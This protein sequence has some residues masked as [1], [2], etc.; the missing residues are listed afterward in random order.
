MT[1][2]AEPSGAAAAAAALA[3]TLP[4]GC[5]SAVVVA[6]GVAGLHDDPVPWRALLI[7]LVWSVPGAMIAAA[8][9]RAVLGWL[10]LAVAAMFTTTGLLEVWLASEPVGPAAAVAWGLWFVDRAGALIVPATTLALVLLP[11]SRLPGPGWRLPVAGA[12]ALQVAL[13]A[14]W[15]LAETPAAD[16]ES[17]RPPALLAL[18]N[19]AG[20]L[21][22]AWAGAADGV[23]WLL[24]LPLL[25]PLAAMA[26][27]IR[28]G[29]ALERQRLAAILLSLVVLVAVILSGRAVLGEWSDL[30][31][32]LAVLLLACVLVSAVLRR[33]LEGVSVVVHHAFVLALLGG[34][35]AATYVVSVGLLAAVGP[36]LSRFGAGVVA[37]LAAL[38]AQ[39][40]HS[41]LQG[42]VDRLLRGDRR[43]PYRAVS[44]LVDS[45]HRAPSLTDVLERVATS[46][47]TSVRLPAVEVTAFGATGRHPPDRAGAAAT[48]TSRGVRV[49]LL[50]G[51]REVGSLWVLPQLGRR[52]RADEV[53]L[54]REL[55][56]HAGV[57]VDAVHLAAQVAEHHRAVVTAREEE[58]RRLGRELHDE[59]GPT[60]AGLAMQL[61]A[62]RPLVRTDPDGVVTRLAQLEVAAAGAL[63]GLRRVAHELRPPVLDQVGLDRA[64]RQ[65]AD[66]LGLSVVEQV[67]EHG[68]LPAAV[69][70]AAYRIVAE[71]LT[72][73][74]RHSGTR[75][76]RLALRQVT[77]DL[78]VSVADDGTGPGTPAGPGLGWAT[79][80]ERT[81]ELGGSLSIRVPEGG[82]TVVTALLPL[83]VPAGAGRPGG[84]T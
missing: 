56:R 28:R 44:R 61:G 63:A 66:S 84:G 4:L 80:R 60:V 15:S 58:R 47:A 34:I 50:A 57:A 32:V 18:D 33:H 42:V 69:E 6:V 14:M 16:P 22:G 38:L 51:D 10:I 36:D 74:A 48:A 78:V 72:N 1:S 20:V 83:D 3:W 43:D 8:R 53:S 2:R 73:V 67:V 11:D 19:P 39:P 71:A 82:G 45:A 26:V 13:V 9:P 12:V 70:V 76:V 27:R 31:D 7:P 55:A 24:Q 81:E 25:L 79:M 68:P 5:L 49:P 30:V 40:L 29:D 65:V 21:P 35:V 23:V 37:A 52:L 54:L 75:Q 64:V 77:D 59:L 46:V 62:L 41:R 17:G